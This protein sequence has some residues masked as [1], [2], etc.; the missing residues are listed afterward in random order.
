MKSPRLLII[1]WSLHHAF[2]SFLNC[3][4]FSINIYRSCWF[5]CCFMYN[6]KIQESL[7]ENVVQ[8]LQKFLTFLLYH[9]FS[10]IGKLILMTVAVL[11]F[12]HLCIRC[13]D[14]N[15]RESHQIEYR[16]CKGDNKLKALY[17]YHLHLT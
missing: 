11:S 13:S 16:L 6:L 2:S 17:I 7:Q 10:G 15:Q 1:V 5:L 8:L 3:I 14:P 12:E 4:F 9:I